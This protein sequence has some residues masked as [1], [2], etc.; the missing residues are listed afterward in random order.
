ML[1]YIAICAYVRER[2]SVY[3]TVQ[4]KGKSVRDINSRAARL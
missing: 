3:G 1:M 2:E 4:R